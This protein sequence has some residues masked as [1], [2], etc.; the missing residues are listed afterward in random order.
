VPDERDVVPPLVG[1]SNGKA[2]KSNFIITEVTPFGRIWTVSF[3]PTS[4]GSGPR[5]TLSFAGKFV[6]G[7]VIAIKEDYEIGD[8]SGGRWF[9]ILDGNSIA[10]ARAYTQMSVDGDL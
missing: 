6:F 9:L 2:G 5:P 4:L 7:S 10:E 1:T 8:Q 3:H